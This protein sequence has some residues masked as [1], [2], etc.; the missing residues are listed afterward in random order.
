[1]VRPPDRQP[2]SLIPVSFASPVIQ[3]E[4]ARDNNTAPG[5]APLF[6]RMA[7]VA[8]LASRGG[9]WC[10]ADAAAAGKP[11]RLVCRAGRRQ[12]GEVT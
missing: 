6:N 4:Y 9:L 1:M 8:G 2:Q 3:A 7:T 11:L 5:A 10:D 12:L